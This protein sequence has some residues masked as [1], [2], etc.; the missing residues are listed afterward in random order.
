LD[1]SI[2]TGREPIGVGTGTGDGRGGAGAVGGLAGSGTGAA[3]AAVMVFE[4]G[5]AP[6]CPA[7]A[8]LAGVPGALPRSRASPGLD[9][10][11]AAAAA[12]GPGLALGLGLGLGFGEGLGLGFGEG[13]GLRPA[14]GLGLGLGLVTGGTTAEALGPAAALPTVA[15]GTIDGTPACGLTPGAATAGPTGGTTSGTTGGTKGVTDGTVGWTTPA[16]GALGGTTGGSMRPG[17]VMPAAAG[18]ALQVS[19]QLLQSFVPASGR[20]PS[21]GLARETL[22]PSRVSQSGGTQP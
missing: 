1:G 9:A 18:P 6:S 15:A 8:G 21:V 17:L 22:L 19:V 3:A 13:L 7:A 12:A 10:A 20:M 14:L 11:P 5:V 4:R 2:G 16:G